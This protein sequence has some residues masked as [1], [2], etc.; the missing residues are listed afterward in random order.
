MVFHYA[1]RRQSEVLVYYL[2]DRGRVKSLRHRG[3]A[4]NID[5]EDGDIVLLPAELEG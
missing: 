4:A 5:E 1:L 3:E 2:N